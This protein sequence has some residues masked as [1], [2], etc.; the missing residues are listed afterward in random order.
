MP[1]TYKLTISVPLT[2]AKKLQAVADQVGKTVEVMLQE[3]LLDRIRH[4]DRPLTV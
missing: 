2:T 3:L 4:A 1:R